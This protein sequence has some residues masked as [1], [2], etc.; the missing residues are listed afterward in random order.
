MYKILRQEQTFHLERI[1]R[2]KEF[3]HPITS[4]EARGLRNLGL[5]ITSSEAR[6]LRNLCQP[7][8]SSEARG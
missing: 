2:L 6:G 8:T 1:E 3:D 7:I 4:S 5:P